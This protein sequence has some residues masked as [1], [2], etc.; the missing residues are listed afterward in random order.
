MA[1]LLV[2]HSD[3]TVLPKTQ[4]KNPAGPVLNC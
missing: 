4:E 3:K 2:S 1:I